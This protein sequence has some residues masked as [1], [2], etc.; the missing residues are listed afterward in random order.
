[1]KGITVSAENRPVVFIHGMWI[2]AQSWQ[3]WID[4]FSEQGYAP[5]APTWPGE[6][7]TVALSRSNPEAA[8]G[9]GIDDI[10][11]H[12]KEVMDALDE[13]PILIGHSL[14][15]LIVEK[16]IGEGRGVAGI[17]IDPAQ[18]QGVLPLP[19]AQLRA[20]LP[21]LKNPTNIRKSVSLTAE[22][23]RYGFGNALP[24]EESDAL[25]EKWAIPSPARPVFQAAAT[26]FVLHSEAKVD[27]HNVNRGPL[28]LV[29]GTAD[30]TVPDV[31]TNA[32]LKQYRD[33]RATTDLLRI[34]GRGHSLT[35]DSGWRTVADEVLA[36]LASN[37]L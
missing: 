7:D 10:A 36:W 2:A 27:T 35:V 6:G 19:I 11:E 23:F 29:S 8:A 9:F 16:L 13:E 24:E 25:H 5:I 1:M 37:H 34:D 4:L 17:A 26:N 3:P 33:S 21:A 22:E 28:L 14:G 31:T 18:I 20:A 32:T 15:G 12:Y 30:H